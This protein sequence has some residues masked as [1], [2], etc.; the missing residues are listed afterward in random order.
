[1]LIILRISSML[2]CAVF[3]YY[4]QTTA[5]FERRLAEMGDYESSGFSVAA[6]LAYDAIW[7][8]AMGIDR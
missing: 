1:M 6:Y 8:L 4:L 3:L 5:E 2:L 7:T